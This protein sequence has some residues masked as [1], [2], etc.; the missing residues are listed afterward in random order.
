MQHLTCQSCGSPLNLEAYDSRFEIIS[1]SHCGGRYDVSDTISIHP[2]LSKKAGQSADDSVAPKPEA[3]N[4]RRRDGGVEYSW[5]NQS[6]LVTLVML[7]ILTAWMFV[8]AFIVIDSLIPDFSWHR[9]NP[10]KFGLINWL[11]IVVFIWLASALV[12]NSNRFFLSMGKLRS[13]QGPVP[14]G[15]RKSVLSNS[16]A[17]LF[18]ARRV[19]QKKE[20][21]PTTYYVLN[22]V[23]INNNLIN[24]PSRFSSIDAALFVEHGIERELG[25]MSRDVAGEA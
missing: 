5:R 3:I 11:L 22:G 23:D 15:W 7:G 17:Q 19:V 24:F 20:D 8:L 16:I 1:C 4:V 21:E 12:L 13:Y 10:A 25:L 6:R 14:W 9:G 2:R 18:V